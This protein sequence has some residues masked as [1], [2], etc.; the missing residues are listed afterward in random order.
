MALG[1]RSAVWAADLAPRL[2]NSAQ[3][4]REAEFWAGL[5]S[6]HQCLSETRQSVAFLGLFTSPFIS[7]VPRSLLAEVGRRDVL[8]LLF[9]RSL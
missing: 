6:L 4:Q 1:Q 7:R 5:W 9:S 2:Q 8:S 3:F